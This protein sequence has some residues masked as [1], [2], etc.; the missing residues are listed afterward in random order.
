MA[1]QVNWQELES[2][3]VIMSIIAAFLWWVFRMGGAVKELKRNGGNSMRDRIER[4]EHKQ[5]QQTKS[6]R[7]IERKLGINECD[8][9]DE[10]LS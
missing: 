3:V 7:R 9:G 10:Y 4:L 2:I 8:E 5:D 6:L 1:T